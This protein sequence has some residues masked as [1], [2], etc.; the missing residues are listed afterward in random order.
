MLAPGEPPARVDEA[1][2]LADLMPTILDLAGVAPPREMRGISLRPA[3]GGGR[4]PARDL[5]FETLTGAIS[6][7]WAELFG[8]R[9]DGWKLIESNDPEL[10][11]LTRDPG[12]L[13]NLAATEPARLAELRQALED[14]GQPM[15]SLDSGEEAVVP[16]DPE[17]EAMLA[18]LGYVAGGTTRSD[19]DDAP[20]PRDFVD[21][22]PE[23]L[24][25]QESLARGGYARTE[26]VCRYVLERD[27]TNLWA[28]AALAQALAGL[29][30]HEEAIV[31]ARRLVEINPEAEAA[32]A[33]LATAYMN[34]NRPAEAQQALET[35]LEAIPGSERLTYLS[36][37][38]AWDA[39][40]DPCGDRTADAIAA[41][42]DSARMRILQ[43]RCQARDGRPEAAL[44]TLKEAVDLGFT[45][46]EMLEEEAEFAAVVALEGFA[47]LR[48]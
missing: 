34:V 39:G 43:A 23:L 41:H 24:A 35:G 12:E 47:T 32:H 44:A 26:A 36:L 30:R 6:Y 7:G 48:P 33:G 31:P 28:L 27:P 42:P 8:V 29:E 22:E 1:V 37:V 14:I 15:T 10:Y 46:L 17:T 21:L 38:A 13:E 5:Y 2:H 3:L 11:D 4:L 9:Y 40:D 45:R 18:S 16:L 19:R 20:H 25:A